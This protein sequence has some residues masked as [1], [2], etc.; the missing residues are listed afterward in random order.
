MHHCRWLAQLHFKTFKLSESNQEK[1]KGKMS[2]FKVIVTILFISAISLSSAHSKK[3][4]LLSKLTNDIIENERVP[5]ILYAKTCWS[6]T[7]D[8][9][10][11]KY[12]S[13]PIQIVN[14]ITPIELPTDDNTNKQWFFIDMNC[15]QYSNFLSNV[16]E[17][18]FAHP[19]RWIFIDAKN[20]SIQHLNFLPGSNIILANRNP[21][22]EQFTLNQGF[23]YIFIP[24]PINYLLRKIIFLKQHIKLAKEIR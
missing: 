23:N 11:V 21:N 10:F 8:I 19:Y 1:F 7:D 13:I 12:I 18:Y 4:A 9:A 17:K 24:F 22:S 3:F 5:S 20:E 14:S 15:K 2:S 6:K 16:D